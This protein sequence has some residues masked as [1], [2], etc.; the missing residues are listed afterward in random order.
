MVK[1]RALTGEHVE[2]PAKRLQRPSLTGW[3]HASKERR[4]SLKENLQRVGLYSR[5]RN[6][7]VLPGAPDPE[8]LVDTQTYH[9]LPRLRMPEWIRSSEVGRSE[10]RRSLQRRYSEPVRATTCPLT[11]VDVDRSRPLL[12]GTSGQFSADEQVLLCQ[13]EALVKVHN[14]GLRSLRHCQGDAPRRACISFRR[15]PQTGASCTHVIVPEAMH[16]PTRTVLDVLVA[17][18]RVV[19]PMWVDRCLGEGRVPPQA[20]NL[21]ESASFP[22][23]SVRKGRPW[24]LRGLRVAVA[25]AYRAE[26]H[27]S[28]SRLC[29]RLWASALG[30]HL[31][32]SLDSATILIV[33]PTSTKRLSPELLQQS[34]VDVVTPHWLIESILAWSPEATLPY[35]V[36]WYGRMLK[37]VSGPLSLTQVQGLTQIESISW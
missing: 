11:E 8:K 5:R 37:E 7:T 23:V 33:P 14:Q 26:N 20:E 19:I 29:L 28:V 1:I 24:P 3:S 6:Q 12:I 34:V 2:L 16:R 4:E 17:G 22:S 10:A 25:G 9:P 27:K 35:R 21:L 30:A 32:D 13:I 31:T 18:E 15:S 36:P